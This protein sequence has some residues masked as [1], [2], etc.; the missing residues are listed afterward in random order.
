LS[1]PEDA[2]WVVENVTSGTATSAPKPASWAMMLIAFGGL[3][4][5]SYRWAWKRSAAA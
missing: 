2:S 1:V 5:A 4:F 3:G